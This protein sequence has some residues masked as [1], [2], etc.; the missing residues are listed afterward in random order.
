MFPVTPSLVKQIAEVLDSGFLVFIHRSTG[1]VRTFLNLEDLP[2]LDEEVEEST[3][4]FLRLES[5]DYQEVKR[6]SPRDAFGMMDDFTEQLADERALQQRL[7]E[8]L[9]KPKPFNR[10]KSVIDNAGQY[11]Q[12]WFAFKNAWQQAW[13]EKQLLKN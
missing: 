5:A 13:V 11:R 2:D 1:A 9:N 3:Q 6:W 4:Q 8:A 7:I 10:F 12:Q